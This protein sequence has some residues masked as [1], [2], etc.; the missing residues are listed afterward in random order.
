M[1]YW[2]YISLYLIMTIQLGYSQSENNPIN[3][4]RYNDNFLVFKKDTLKEGVDKLKYRKLTDQTFI[5]FGGDLREQ[6]QY[7]DN[8]SF[9]D[10]PPGTKKTDVGQLWHRL[11]VHSQ[12]DIGSKTRIFLQLNSTFRFF[13]PNPLTP[14]IDE[15]QLS[16]HQAFIDYQLHKK[17]MIRAGRQE[18]IYG[19]SRLL[20]FREG[21][22][23]RL[24]F[25]GVVVKYRSGPT[26]IDVLAMTPVTSRQKVFDDTS[27]EDALLGVYGT[28][29]VVPKK[30]LLDYYFINFTSNRRRYNY[31]AGKETRQIFG[32]RLFSKNDRLNYELEATYQTGTFNALTI[33]AYGLSGDI[34]Y[35]LATKH[36][37]IL[38][39]AA[40]YIS[41]DKARNDQ[42]LNTYNPLF[43][44]PQYGLAAPIGSINIE[45]VNPYLK[46]SPI[47][48]VTVFALVY[49]MQRQSNQDGTYSPGAEQ[50]LPRRMELYTSVNRRIGTQYALE[51]NY[52]LSK[53]LSIGVDGAWFKAGR[54]VK[55]TGSGQNITYV[56][57]RI[58]YKL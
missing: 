6:Y 26:T 28:T 24:T 33:N 10:G 7:F 47:K 21:P 56:S 29:S 36:N 5:S 15:N 27:F 20:S 17:W 1:R 13:N 57:G 43:S 48:K 16:L 30:L 49:F 32:S 11:M 18:I 38:G 55:E 50:L 22:N 31:V 25:D 46:I 19:N 23:T 41:G 4:L 40:N 45:S 52:S 14:E 2:Y 3:I 42:I 35:V 51:T 8:Q 37:L 12:L 53:N 34:S 39:I 54:Y 44:R 58:S 9:G